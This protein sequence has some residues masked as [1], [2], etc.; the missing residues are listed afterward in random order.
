MRGALAWVG[1]HARAATIAEEALAVEIAERDAKV[2]VLFFSSRFPLVD[3]CVLL[4]FVFHV[5]NRFS[6]CCLLST[7]NLYIS[8]ERRE[9]RPQVR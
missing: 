6:S 2:L 5:D 1:L 4:V 3:V 8:N 9:R 7:E